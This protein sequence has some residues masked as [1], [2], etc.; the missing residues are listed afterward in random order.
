MSD[1]FKPVLARLAAGEILTEAE[2]GAFFQA[3]LRGE[4]TPAQIAS[5]VTAMRVRGETVSEIAA[6]AAAM[7][8]AGSRLDHG[9]DVIDTCGTGGDGAHTYNISTAAALVAAGA[10]A[11]VAK[12]G[13]RSL[14]SRSGSSDVLAA[15]GVNIEA[16]AEQSR[17]ALEHARICFMFAPAYHGAMRHVTPVRAELGFRTIFNLMGPLSNPAGARRQLLG[18]YDPSLVQPVAE[19]LGRLGATR[20]WVVHGAGL[21]EI[22]TTGVTEVAE[23]RDGCVTRFQI[24]PDMVG[25]TTVSPAALRGGEPQENAAALR[26]V[27]EGEPGAYRD[28]VVLNA[29]AALLVAD[30]ANDLASGADMAAESLQSGRALGALQMLVEASWS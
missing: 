29:A 4:A 2:T 28:A 16:S 18:V 11:R 27:L 26:R 13:T 9:F 6:G 10:G 15:L 22:T 25:M 20:S 17:R 19:V 8:Q 23:W 14:S 7:R 24:T 30:L 3:C 21:D 5:A 12:H 1:T